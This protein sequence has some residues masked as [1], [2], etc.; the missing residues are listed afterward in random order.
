MLQWAFTSTL[1]TNEKKKSQQKKKG[2]ELNKN[3]KAKNH[4][5]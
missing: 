3:F 4:N 1:E 2:G 5:A